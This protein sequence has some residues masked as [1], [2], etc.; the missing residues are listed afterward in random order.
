METSK[1]N[2]SKM[3]WNPL[4]SVDDDE[5][6]VGYCSLNCKSC[7]SRSK[8]RKELGILFKVS[9]QDLPLEFYSHIF[10]PFKNIKQVMNFLEFLPQMGQ[11]QICCTSEKMPCKTP[12]EVRIC[13]KKKS[14]R[15]CAEC[16]DYST[17]SKLAHVALRHE[18]LLSD[19]DLIKEKGL[20]Y[21]VKE[22]VAKYQLK[23]ILIE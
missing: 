6:L 4:T 20:D 13:V 8:R 5:Q 23:P 2:M 9:L 22:I 3:M 19:L 10:P 16:T 1:Q 18:T 12:C 21:Y 17:C 14:L 7:L 15:T 11:G